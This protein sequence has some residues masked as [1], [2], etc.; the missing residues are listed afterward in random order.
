[1]KKEK[2]VLGESCEEKKARG[3]PGRETRD[4]AAMG[5]VAWQKPTPQMM[6]VTKL[7]MIF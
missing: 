4:M 1:M 6:H 3:T 5:D 7:G 2:S